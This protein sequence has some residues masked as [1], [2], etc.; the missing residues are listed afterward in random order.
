[1]SQLYE[2]LVHRADDKETLSEICE[3][4]GKYTCSAYQLS[5]QYGKYVNPSSSSSISL[6]ARDLLTT[7][8]IRRISRPYQV[9]VSR[10]HSA[11]MVSPE[12]SQW[13]FNC[14]C[15]LG[16]KEHNRKVREERERKRPVTSTI[17]GTYR[18]GTFGCIIPR[19][20]K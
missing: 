10:S 16:D 18:S 1:M 12:L 13:K 4:M 20:C 19:T 3:K 14:M 11:M 9:V 17:Q 15:G 6:V 7:D 2:F 8:G 5:S